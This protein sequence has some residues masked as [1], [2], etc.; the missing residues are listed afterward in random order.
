MLVSS[1]L[2]GRTSAG[3]IRRSLESN[4]REFAEIVDL[5]SSLIYGPRIT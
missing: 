3:S 2:V 5:R 1:R 4:A